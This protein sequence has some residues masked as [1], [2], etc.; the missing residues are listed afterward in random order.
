MPSSIESSVSSTVTGRVLAVAKYLPSLFSSS[1]RICAVA[2]V[3]SSALPRDNVICGDWSETLP[4]IILPMLF[5]LC[6]RVRVSEISRSF[7]HLFVI[8]SKP[9]VFFLK[10]V[11]L[12]SE[13]E[14]A[15]IGFS[16]SSSASM[17]ITVLII[18]LRGLMRRQKS[19]VHCGLQKTETFFCVPRGIWTVCEN[20]C[21]KP[22]YLS[23]L[24]PSL[25]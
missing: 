21:A 24:F 23:L 16:C 5:S 8:P 10:K 1:Q 17:A 18:G 15:F 4:Q 11:S 13:T 14:S 3:R 2:V 6:E 19:R 7:T 25:S 20:S 22:T 9:M 12:S